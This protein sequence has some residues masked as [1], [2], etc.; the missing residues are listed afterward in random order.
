MQCSYCNAPME[1]FM[2]ASRRSIVSIAVFDVL[3]ALAA[4]GYWYEAHR[5]K[6]GQAASNGGINVTDGGDRG[7][8]TLRKALFIAA[9]ADNETT[10]SIQVPKISLET[11][12]PPLVNAHG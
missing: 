10:I 1:A 4:G 9:A 12:L 3:A 5:A 2:T 8:G 6:P 7:A 11:A